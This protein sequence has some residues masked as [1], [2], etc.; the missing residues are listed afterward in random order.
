MRRWGYIKGHPIAPTEA[1]PPMPLTDAAIRRA[2]PSD[3]QQKIS[4]GGGPVPLPHPDRRAQLA[5][6]V[7]HRRQG[8]AAV[9]RP[10]PGCLVGSRS[11][12]PRRSPTPAGQR[13]R[14]G[15][16]EEGCRPRPLRPRLGQLRDH[17][18]R[19]AGH[20]SLGAQLCGEDRSL[21]EVRRMAVDRV[22]FGSWPHRAG[23]PSGSP[24]HRGPR[25]DRVRAPN[26]AELRPDHAVRR[27]HRPRRAQ[28][29]RR[30]EGCLGSGEGAPSRHTADL[31]SPARRCGWHRWRSCVLANCGTRNGRNSTSTPPCGPS[32]PA[33]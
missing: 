23:L 15:C 10:L 22:A 6:E 17:R 25:R 12:G 29:R 13:C 16:A 18:Q 14:P 27:G 33:R 5:L 1:I 8:E 21:D 30:S 19:V 3:N 7:P 28:S 26:H 31:P 20:A 9:D 32:P 2:R 11:R 24:A 4:D